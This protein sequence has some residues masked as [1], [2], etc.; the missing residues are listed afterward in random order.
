MSSEKP[1]TRKRNVVDI[2]PRF[3]RIATAETY[4]GIGRSKLYEMAARTP[5]LFRK[6]D[7]AT[8]VDF[9]VLDDVLD[10]LP[11]AEVKAPHKPN[12]NP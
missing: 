2:R 4:A 12:D 8:I 6:N 9:D 1:K 7:R 11:Y 3:G 5:G 10:A